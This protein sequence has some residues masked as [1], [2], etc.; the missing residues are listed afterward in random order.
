MITK[1]V[2]LVLLIW[3]GFRIYNWMQKKSSIDSSKTIVQ[4]MVSCDKCGIHIPANEAIKS[5][6]KYFCSR[7]HLLNKD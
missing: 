4:D 7:D 5:G 6:E 3:L 1:L 2:I